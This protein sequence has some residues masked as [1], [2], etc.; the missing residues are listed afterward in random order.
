MELKG[1]TVLVVDDEKDLCEILATE[2]ASLGANT[3]MAHNVKQALDLIEGHDVALVISDIR[4]PGSSGVELLDTI[5]KTRVNL[6]VILITGFADITVAEALGRGAE[7]VVNKPFDMDSLFEL[8][9][10]LVKPLTERWMREV[11]C[12]KITTVGE[13]KLSYGRGGFFVP[14][15]PLPK[16]GALFQLVIDRGT[17]PQKTFEVV[18][19]WG[20]P[21]KKD[22]PEGWGAEIQAWDEKTAADGWDNETKIPFIPQN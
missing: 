14:G 2:L 17:L 10:K 8:C 12:D 7:A 16:V 22:G 6:P 18:C 11:K 13:E 21:Q 15:G 19:R 3:L 5:R 1:K 9:E 20:R 4:M